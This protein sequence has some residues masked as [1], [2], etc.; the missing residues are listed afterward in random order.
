[1]VLYEV[2]T[3]IGT[4]AVFTRAEEGND[5]KPALLKRT[6]SRSSRSVCVLDLLMIWARST[7]DIH[8][9]FHFHLYT[10]I[11]PNTFYNSLGLTMN[12]HPL[13]AT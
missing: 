5:P 6:H 2:A 13:I 3:H 8:I 9:H 1:M 7:N 4:R 10:Q 11:L 12:H